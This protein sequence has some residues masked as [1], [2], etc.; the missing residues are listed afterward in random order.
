MIKNGVFDRFLKLKVIIGH[1]GE[2][3]LFDFWRINHW[4]ED[5]VK[6]NG[7]AAKKTLTE[8]IWVT[9]SGYT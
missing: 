4:F 2:Y 9:T 6:I 8:N 7:M 3:I 5:F 1:L